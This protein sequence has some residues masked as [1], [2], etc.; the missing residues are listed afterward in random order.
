MSADQYYTIDSNVQ[1]IDE[2]FSRAIDEDEDDRQ[3]REGV[4]VARRLV[5]AFILIMI[6][7]AVCWVVLPQF[8]MHLPPLAVLAIFGFM[9][10]ASLATLFEGRPRR[11][12]STPPDDARPISCC[13]VRPVGELSRKRAD[14]LAGPGSSCGCG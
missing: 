10:F 14:D 2:L 7:G 12:R 1:D 4:R 9:A 3:R 5:I 6:T 8:G 13:G 11:A